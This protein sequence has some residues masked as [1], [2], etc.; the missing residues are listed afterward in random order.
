MIK[1]IAA[2]LIS[3]GLASAALAQTKFTMPPPAGVS[4]M[5]VQVVTACGAASGL[6]NNNTAYLAM[7]T[8]G[9]LCTNAT[10][11][12]GG[13]GT[14]SNFGSAFPTPGTAV[15]F[16]DGTNMVAARVRNPGSSAVIGDGAL[17]VVDPNVLAA[18]NSAI[19]AGTNTIGNAGQLAYPVGAVP[20][21]N[22]ATATTTGAVAT[23]AGA[24]SV[25]TYICGFSVRANATAATTVNIV[26][27][28]TISGS[29][30]FT[31]W[32]AP[33]AS[34]L[35]VAEMIFPQCVPASAQNTAI[36]VTGG[37]PGA[38]GINSATAW[39]YKL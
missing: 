39:G 7:D 3:L 31:Q 8:S 4:V 35:G 13:G 24:A 5:G 6:A 19:P 26:V 29:L 20:Y 15:G 34:G 1:A 23:L 18:I 30:N 12:G 14:S 22:S 2:L 9:N 36:V 25:T 21:T 16:T 37:A 27:S 33:A 28:G 32:V 17:V 38:G 11:G 10:G